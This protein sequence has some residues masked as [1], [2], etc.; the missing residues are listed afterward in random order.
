MGVNEFDVEGP[1]LMIILTFPANA[2]IGSA[3]FAQQDG[4]SLLSLES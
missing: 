1:D 3:E 4:L 2:G